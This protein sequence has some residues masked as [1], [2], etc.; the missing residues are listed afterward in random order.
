MIVKGTNLPSL[1]ID[2]DGDGLPDINIDADGDGIPETNIDIDGDGKADVN[3]DPDK[4]GI[5]QSDPY[6]ITEWKPTIQGKG[7]G[8]HFLTMTLDDDKEPEPDNPNDDHLGDKNS[9]VQGNYYP[10]DNTGGAKSTG[11]ALTGDTT[12]IMMYMGFGCMAMGMMLFIIFKK[13]Q[14]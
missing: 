2:L 6:E 14:S 7:N 5:V 1:N 8:F 13:K 11:G 4:T 9:D 10:G 3:L 12:N